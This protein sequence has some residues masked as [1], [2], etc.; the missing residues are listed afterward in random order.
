[1]LLHWCL[2]GEGSKTWRRLK[3]WGSCR[4]K[5]HTTWGRGRC[6]QF[7]INLSRWTRAINLILNAIREEV[8]NGGWVVFSFIFR[9]RPY[10]GSKQ[11]IIIWHFLLGGLLRYQL[12]ASFRLDTLP[13]P[14]ITAT[15]K[16]LLI[17]W[18]LIHW[19]CSC[20]CWRIVIVVVTC[21]HSWRRG[22]FFETSRRG[23]MY[24][25]LI[26]EV[27]GPHCR[28]LLRMFL[29]I[30]PHLLLTW[31]AADKLLQICGTWLTDRVELHIVVKRLLLLLELLLL[32]RRKGR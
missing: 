30:V 14:N 1:M 20:L 23:E 10:S 6:Y 22:K 12:T 28:I 31:E 11:W 4:R 2:H 15:S 27:W 3:G 7:V 26:V 24:S 32:L 29:I 21:L 16:L 9:V 13:N 25:W 17:M 5:I 19:H 18:V 8:S